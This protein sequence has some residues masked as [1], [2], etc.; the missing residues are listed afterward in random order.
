MPARRFSQ[1]RELI[2]QAVQ[3][4]KEHPSAEVIYQRL[5]PEMPKLSL[6]TVYRNLHQMAEEGRLMEIPG[7]V[8]RFDAN[9]LPHPH[10]ICRDCG[11]VS[12]VDM[13]YDLGLDRAMEGRGFVV[14]NHDLT[15]FGICPCCLGENNSIQS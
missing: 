7:P 11:G 9:T 2:Y 5:K 14:Q 8:N 3:A 12:D 10:F 13:P 6:G 4:S 1:Q 15:F